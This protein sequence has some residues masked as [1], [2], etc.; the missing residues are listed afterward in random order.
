MTVHLVI[1][2]CILTS[3]KHPICMH[4]HTIRGSLFW[5][6]VNLEQMP[7]YSDRPRLTPSLCLWCIYLQCWLAESPTPHPKQKIP[8]IKSESNCASQCRK[9]GCLVLLLIIRRAV[10]SHGIVREPGGQRFRNEKSPRWLCVN[11]RSGHLNK[12]KLLINAMQTQSFARRRLFDWT[13]C[14]LLALGS[15]SDILISIVLR[16]VRTISVLNIDVCRSML[17]LNWW[18]KGLW[19]SRRRRRRPG[20]DHTLPWKPLWLALICRRRMHISDQTLQTGERSN[21]MLPPEWM[22]F[23]LML[24]W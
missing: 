7:F 3:T 13:A 24:V 23:Y 1:C 10:E 17:L 4:E 18:N 14:A 21:R 5:I 22:N 20:Q 16:W 15:H 6:S 12:H 2:T 19:G 9:K 11:K 8:L